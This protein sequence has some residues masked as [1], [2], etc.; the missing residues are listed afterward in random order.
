MGVDETDLAIGKHPLAKEMR[1]QRG[2]VH[3]LGMVGVNGVAGFDGKHDRSSSCV[4][5]GRARPRLTAGFVRQSSP[6]A[7]F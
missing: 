1:P 2:G 5:S 7:H 6:A 3:P 4:S